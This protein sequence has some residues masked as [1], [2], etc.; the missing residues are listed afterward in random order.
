MPVAAGEDGR[1]ETDVVGAV[2]GARVHQ[3]G[4]YLHRPGLD[5]D[6]E[7]GVP[8]VTAVLDVRPF[9]DEEVDAVHLAHGG[10]DG[11]GTLPHLVRL[12]DIRPEVY[13]VLAHLAVAVEGGPPEGAG[14]GLGGVVDVGPT[15]HQLL[16]ERQL[17]ERRGGP[18]RGRA[19]D[20][21]PA[22]DHGRCLL[23]QVDAV[24]AQNVLEAIFGAFEDGNDERRLVFL[25]FAGYETSLKNFFQ[26]GVRQLG[27]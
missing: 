25:C 2:L 19:G 27:L 13:E 14:L 8:V 3:Y 1:S 12:V 18:E 26:L 9:G 17:P 15:P 21:V 24:V 16:H 11:E 6:V 4:G 23:F 20:G 5:A 22:L 10:G 7:R